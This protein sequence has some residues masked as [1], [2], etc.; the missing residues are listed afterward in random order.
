MMLKRICVVMTIIALVFA[1]TACKSPSEMAAEKMMEGIIEQATGA[2]VDFDSDDGN[3][4]IKTSEG[5]TNFS[6]EGITIHGEDGKTSISTGEN[7][8]WPADY[9]GDIP[10]PK[11][12]NFVAVISSPVKSSVQFAGMSIEDAKSYYQSLIDLGYESKSGDDIVTDEI[13]SYIGIKGDQQVA[14]V[15][16]ADGFTTIILEKVEEN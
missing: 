1:L 9:M 14:F 8:E 11:G 12:Y 13:I 3:L 10:E 16:L 5:E 4:T 6:D 7:L 2:D 15:R